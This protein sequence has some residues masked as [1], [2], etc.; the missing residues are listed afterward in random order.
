MVI[1]QMDQRKVT[2][3]TDRSWETGL[4]PSGNPGDSQCPGSRLILLRTWRGGAF[5]SGAARHRT[6]VRGKAAV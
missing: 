1:C 2:Y 4:S 3:R 6:I 5:K